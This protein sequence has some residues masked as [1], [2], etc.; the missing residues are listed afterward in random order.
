MCEEDGSREIGFLPE[1]LLIWLTDYNNIRNKYSSFDPPIVSFLFNCIYFHFYFYLSDFDV[2]SMQWFDPIPF[3]VVS[4]FHSQ[5]EKAPSWLLWLWAS[6]E[7][8]LSQTEE[9][10]WRTLWRLVISK[11]VYIMFYSEIMHFF[12]TSSRHL[13]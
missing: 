5:V 8:P 11:S 2:I 9:Y 6:V 7:R 1:N 10:R 3:F 4:N 13:Y 12:F